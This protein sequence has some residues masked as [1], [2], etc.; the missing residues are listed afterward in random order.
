MGVAVA[1]FKI[2][3]ENNIKDNGIVVSGALVEYRICQNK[4]EVILYY[5]SYG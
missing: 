5:V 1:Q 2:Q 3:C 4:V